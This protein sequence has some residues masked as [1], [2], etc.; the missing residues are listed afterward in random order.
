MNK[1]LITGGCG[2]IGSHTCYVLLEA[3]YE[4]IV[5]DS[6]INSTKISLSR[7]KELEYSGEVDFERN[8]KFFHGDIRD[9]KLLEAI[10]SEA[11]KENKPIEAV[12]HFAGLKSVSESIKL[13]LSYWDA[14]VGG[15]IAL[16]EVMK[17]FDCKTI[18]FSSS[19]SIY[20]FEGDKLLN[21]DDLINPSS[22][23]GKTKETIENILFSVFESA[24]S[25]WRIANLRY[26]NPIGAHPS[27]TIGENFSE[28]S[29][30]LFPHIC[31]V[32]AGFTNNLNIYGNDWPTE[33]G[34]CIRDYIHVLDLA[35][36][37][38]SAIKMLD[39]SS[40][41]FVN[42]NIGTGKGTSVLELAQTFE[43][44]NKCKIPIVFEKRRKGDI[45]FSVANNALALNLLNWSPQETLEDMC[46]DGW[47]WLIKNPNGYED[48]I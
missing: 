48:K 44:V 22:P 41:I 7:L 21:E 47:K 30:N 43:K 31:M 19:A 40:S 17:Q 29:D 13:P 10:F 14:N 37:H 27:G 6:N 38:M 42:V 32:A 1:I 12:I 20:H 45:P 25:K 3:G 28:K 33:D 24:K 46:R 26:F 34:T 2:Y 23:Y 35:K 36:A 8:L 18:V 16:L 39:K 11:E 15:T 5:I 4:L 9:K